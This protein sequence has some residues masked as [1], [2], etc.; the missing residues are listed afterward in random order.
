M[1]HRTMR[2]FINLGVLCLAVISLVVALN[3]ADNGLETTA[4]WVLGLIGA[5][6]LMVSI[7]RMQGQQS[8]S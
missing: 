4:R 2:F 5:G 7:F 6:M 8:A 1:P 3:W